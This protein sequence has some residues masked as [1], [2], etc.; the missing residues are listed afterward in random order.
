MKKSSFLGDWLRL[1]LVFYFGAALF[2]GGILAVACA[3]YWSLE[4]V[5]TVFTNPVYVG[6]LRG[7]AVLILLVSAFVTLIDEGD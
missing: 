3:A 7:G 1:T 2:F 4:P 5:V 6:A